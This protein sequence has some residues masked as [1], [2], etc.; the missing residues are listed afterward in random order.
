MLSSNS[1]LHSRY[2]TLHLHSKTNKLRKIQKKKQQI[3]KTMKIHGFYPDF[4]P[5]SLPPFPH[6]S[7]S[8][9]HRARAP[10][11]GAAAAPDHRPCWLSRDR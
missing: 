8:P 2:I 7:P 10:R 4:H 1:S 3:E 9:R 6:P 11:R 5:A